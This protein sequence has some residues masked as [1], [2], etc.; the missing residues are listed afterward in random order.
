VKN[1]NHIKNSSLSFY[2]N[3]HHSVAFS[4]IIDRRGNSCSLS[5]LSSIQDVW[6][7][8]QSHEH[9]WIF[10][11]FYIKHP[12]KNIL[13]EESPFLFQV[14]KKYC[15]MQCGPQVDGVSNMNCKKRKCYNQL[16]SKQR[17]QRTA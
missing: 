15:D 2:K 4:L 3:I 6:Y 1:R 13:K 16:F 11:G 14:G 7:A 17:D 9:D 12:T 8:T 5:Q 10:G